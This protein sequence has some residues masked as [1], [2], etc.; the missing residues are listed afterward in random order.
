MKATY[1]NNNNKHAKY[2][3]ISIITDIC[4]YLEV[5]ILAKSKSLKFKLVV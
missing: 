3:I 4:L 5:D 2:Q 1:D